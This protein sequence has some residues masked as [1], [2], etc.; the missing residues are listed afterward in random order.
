MR[1][2]LSG[3]EFLDEAGDYPSLSVIDW[4]NDHSKYARLTRGINIIVEKLGISE[5]FIKH[6]LGHQEKDSDRWIIL[7]EFEHK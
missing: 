4:S 5:D 1:P 2:K 6:K 7:Y 3:W